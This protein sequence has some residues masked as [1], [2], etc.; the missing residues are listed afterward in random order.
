MAGEILRGNGVGVIVASSGAEALGILE[1]SRFDLVLL[2]L[3]MPDMGGVE[4]ARRIKANPETAR[5][6]VIAMSADTIDGEASRLREIGMDDYIAKPVE[7]ATL[8]N[9]VELDHFRFVPPNIARHRSTDRMAYSVLCPSFRM[10][11]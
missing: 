4:T 5:L 3:K 7:P 9:V 10:R 2:D 6:P 11:T 8:K 1:T